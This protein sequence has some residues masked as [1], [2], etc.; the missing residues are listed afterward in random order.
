[1]KYGALDYILKYQMNSSSLLSVLNNAAIE[2]EKVRRE[3]NEKSHLMQVAYKEKK[4]NQKH[5]WKEFINGCY[6]SESAMRKTDELSIEFPKWDF[7]TVLVKFEHPIE[8]NKINLKNIFHDVTYY[9]I[10]LDEEL[11][12]LVHIDQKSYLFVQSKINEIVKK[13]SVCL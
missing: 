11:V 8:Q 7:M 3:F 10:E 6:D 2:V 13:L 9:Q 4:Q 12:F 1:M 5:F